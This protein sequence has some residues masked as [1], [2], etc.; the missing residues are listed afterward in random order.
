MDNLQERWAGG[1]SSKQ[2]LLWIEKP[3]MRSLS[4]DQTTRIITI[5]NS[6][7]GNLQLT[8]YELIWA[9][10]F[11][12]YSARE[13]PQLQEDMISEETKTK[14]SLPK[15]RKDFSHLI[16]GDLQKS[17]S[18]RDNFKRYSKKKYL[19]FQFPYFNTIAKACGLPAKFPWMTSI[20]EK[21]NMFKS[22]HNRRIS[23]TS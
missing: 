7:K 8:V 16:R 13:I 3:S 15:S 10:I 5:Y 23:I 22:S 18:H 12:L 14:F 17:K 19:R 4:P 9:E 6:L 2:R 11:H 21:Q 1:R 20:L